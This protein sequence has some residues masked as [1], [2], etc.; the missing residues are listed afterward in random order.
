V[1][2]LV[3]LP[4]EVEVNAAGEPV[5]VHVPGNPEPIPVDDLGE[6]Y[7]MW[8]GVLR[9]EPQR[10]VFQAKFGGAIGEL[11]CLRKHGD[12]SKPGDWV[13]HRGMD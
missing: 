7:V 12:R 2:R 6:H 13:I 9:G 11:H 4:V 5:A 8:V 3:N 1:S 10:E